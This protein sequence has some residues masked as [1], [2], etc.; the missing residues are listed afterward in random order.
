[1]LDI[2]KG[3]EHCGGDRNDYCSILQFILENSNERI[4][5]LHTFLEKEDFT[6]YTIAVHS[7]KS[8]LANIGAIELSEYAKRLEYAGKEGR[9]EDIRAGHEGFI[10]LYQSLMVEIELYL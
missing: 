5:R 6:N 2:R 7:M 8:T 10:E 1:M 9:F 3:I 4:Q